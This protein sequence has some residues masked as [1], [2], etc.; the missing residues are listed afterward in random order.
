MT[1]ENGDGT[2]SQRNT[3]FVKPL[4]GDTENIES[5]NYENGEILDDCE[6]AQ[7]SDEE[8]RPTRNRKL[9]ER[10]KDYVMY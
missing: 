8:R 6:T 10:F 4:I 3:S 7:Q 1:L 2:I 9:P 5:D